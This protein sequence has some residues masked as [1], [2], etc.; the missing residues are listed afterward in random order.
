MVLHWHDQWVQ[1]GTAK[2]GQVVW[3]FL[4]VQ[5]LKQASKIGNSDIWL[6]PTSLSSLWNSRYCWK[7]HRFWPRVKQG[8]FDA[9]LPGEQHM[10]SL[11]GQHDTIPVGHLEL[12]SSGLKSSARDHSPYIHHHLVA[13]QWNCIFHPEKWTSCCHLM[14]PFASFL[15]PS[16]PPRSEKSEYHWHR[17]CSFRSQPGSCCRHQGV[18]IPWWTRKIAGDRMLQRPRYGI[19]DFSPFC[20]ID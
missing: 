12:G 1:V 11:W 19:V 4:S 14:N 8:N 18:K 9:S 6:S 2:L 3:P 7:F 20:K 16:S 5:K 10:H 13:S 17:S 15:R